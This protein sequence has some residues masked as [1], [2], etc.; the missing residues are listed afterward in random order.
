MP[1]TL[2]TRYSAG[3]EKQSVLLLPNRGT[4]GETLLLEGEEPAHMHCSAVET[5]M[6]SHSQGNQQVK[7]REPINTGWDLPA[8]ASLT[9]DRGHV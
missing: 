8:H 9:E 7:L 1:V 3:L 4:T 6:R 2:A 5:H